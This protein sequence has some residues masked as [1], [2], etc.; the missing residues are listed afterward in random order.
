MTQTDQDRK[1]KALRTA[2][3]SLKIA[4][5]DLRLARAKY[6]QAVNDLVENEL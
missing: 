3:K 6:N 1:V 2:T 5:D 4:Q